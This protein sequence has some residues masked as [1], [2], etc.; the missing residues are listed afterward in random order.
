M[1]DE[2]GRIDRTETFKRWVGWAGNVNNFGI[3]MK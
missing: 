3:E 1:I 2:M